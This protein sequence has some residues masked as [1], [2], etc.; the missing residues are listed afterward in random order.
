[1]YDENIQML[2][3][4]VPDSVFWRFLNITTVNYEGFYNVSDVLHIMVHSRIQDYQFLRYLI[5]RL[6]LLTIKQFSSKYT[7]YSIKEYEHTQYEC[8]E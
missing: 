1:M 3:V 6:P 4:P 7:L 8:S 2:I 5:I